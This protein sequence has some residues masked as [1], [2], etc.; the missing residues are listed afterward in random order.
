MTQELQEYQIGLFVE[1]YHDMLGYI[2]N[3]F[4]KEEKKSVL[5]T[6]LELGNGEYE[7]GYDLLTVVASTLPFLTNIHMRHYSI[8]EK[9]IQYIFGNRIK[10]LISKLEE[11][12]NKN[13]IPF[14]PNAYFE[15][16]K[17]RFDN[18]GNYE[19]PLVIAQEVKL[20]ASYQKYNPQVAT[21]P[22]EYILNLTFDQHDTGNFNKYVTY[23]VNY[24]RYL[25]AGKFKFPGR[26]DWK[27]KNNEKKKGQRRIFWASKNPSKKDK[28]RNFADMHR[29]NM[30][31][32]LAHIVT[33][34]GMI[35]KNEYELLTQEE[36]YEYLFHELEEYWK[37]FT[38]IMI[39]PKNRGEWPDDNF[40]IDNV[41]DIA[42]GY[43]LIARCM[44][45]YDRIPA[46]LYAQLNILFYSPMCEPQE[47]DELYSG[48]Y[49]TPFRERARLHVAEQALMF[50]SEYAL[51]FLYTVTKGPSFAKK[52]NVNVERKEYKVQDYKLLEIGSCYE[53][54]ISYVNMITSKKKYCM[55]LPHK[56]KGTYEWRHLQ[57]KNT[58]FGDGLFSRYAIKAGSMI[59][60][61]GRILCNAEYQLRKKNSKG[62]HLY[63]IHVDL[64]DHADSNGRQIYR[65]QSIKI[66]GDP[67]FYRNIHNIGCNGLAIA[68]KA[69][70]PTRYTQINSKFKQNAIV[71]IKDIE[72]DTEILLDYGNDYDRYHEGKPYNR[73]EIPPGFIIGGDESIEKMIYP[74][75]FKGAI[76][77]HYFT[78]IKNTMKIP[79]PYLAQEISD[80]KKLQKNK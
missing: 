76:F 42:R 52:N 40:A 23:A 2:I 75:G 21:F 12:M 34:Y 53:E 38:E 59:P 10:P 69:N 17:S 18:I 30:L 11:H 43:L 61:F 54:D 79:P 80:L 25:F 8:Y 41:F 63:P 24:D 66:D 50:I 14:V 44:N 6:V 51:F 28:P 4:D 19:Q 55:L 73:A 72:P 74:K 36:D 48:N 70:E 22:S 32:K 58:K 78:I 71:I 49:T 29:I 62:T 3:G 31:G 57:I 67:N 26:V 16:A 1:R 37:F 13:I 64:L 39:Q 56:T 5:D 77:T 9:E 65:K 45:W 46:H 60:V 35:N 15:R 20:P 33:D 47:L 7:R 68:M 27:T